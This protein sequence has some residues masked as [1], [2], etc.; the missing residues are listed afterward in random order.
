VGE[1]DDRR[2]PPHVQLLSTAVFLVLVSSHASYASCRPA[3]P[4]DSQGLHW[5]LIENA[6]CGLTLHRY[7]KTSSSGLDP[8]ISTRSFGVCR[9]FELR[10]PVKPG[11]TSRRKC[12]A[13]L[14]GAL[15]C[16]REAVRT[17]LELRAGNRRARGGAHRC[18]V[19]RRFVGATRGVI[20]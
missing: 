4:V 13:V 1:G 3:Y 16:Y 8:R 19:A 11:M 7:R 15:H 6:R 12:K 5:A 17:E 9:G 18:R 2:M 14:T 10:S 20:G